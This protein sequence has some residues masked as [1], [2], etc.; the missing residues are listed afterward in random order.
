LNCGLLSAEL[1]SYDDLIVTLGC[2]RYVI[3]ICMSGDFVVWFDE[4]AVVTMSLWLC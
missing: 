3:P 1:S 4:A 2:C